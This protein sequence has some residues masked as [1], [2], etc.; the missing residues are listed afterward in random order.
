MNDERRRVL[1]V[2]DSPTQ[3]Q[4][5][6]LFLEAEGLAVIPAESAEAALEVL[7]TARVD[8]VVL[9]YHLPGMNGDDFC[10]EIRMNVNTRALPVLMLTVEGSDAAQLLAL[11]SGADDYLPKTADPDVLRLRVRALLRKSQGTAPILD[12]ENRFSRARVLTIDDSP[13][14]LH[15]LAADLRI[16]HYIVDTA[17]SAA[18]GLEKVRA[19]AYDC[20]LIDFDLSGSDGAQVCRSI[21]EMQNE[22]TSAPV[23]IVLTSHNDTEHMTR[24]FTA[25]AD[26]YICKSTDMAVIRARVR[27]LL[28]RKFLV[29]E[30]QHILNELKEKEL[31][32]IRAKAEKESAE[33]RALMADQLAEANREL[34]RV[35]RNLDLL[36]KELEQFAYAAA[37][38]LQEPLRMIG[39]YSQ[40]LQARYAQ[41]L[42][43]RA[44]QYVAYCVDGA[45]RMDLLIKGLLDYARATQSSDEV[46]HPV[47]CDAVLDRALANLQGVVLET[48]AEIVRGPL[49][50]L[51]VEEIR[52]QQLLQNLVGN[53]LKYRRSGVVPRVVIS[54]E[55]QADEWLFAVSDNGIGIEP[56]QLAS[57]FGAFKRLHQKGYSGTGLGLAI[58]Q[59]IVQHYGGRIW[60]ESEPDSGSTFYFTLPA[61][62]EVNS[63]EGQCPPRAAG[64]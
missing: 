36:N 24:G 17:E 8:V 51:C 37:H 7:N 26:D 63:G 44:A 58:C 54:A 23:L 64:R 18:E 55:R 1:L 53:A 46:A 30:N 48:A 38:D 42:D 47:N 62:L 11:D 9:D 60:V 32:T 57:V 22:R 25:G 29:E 4:R 33:L 3:A 2:E 52:I 49:P 20:V 40:L 16:E 50:S 43:E 13:T 31:E 61:R 56:S 45:Q 6:R 19:S 5:L 21:R 27:A 12:I 41:A 34:E 28:R 39:I 59:R 10:R 35:N 15:R 14:Y